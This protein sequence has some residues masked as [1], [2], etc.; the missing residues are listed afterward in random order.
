MAVNTEFLGRTYPT[1]GPY[2]VTAEGVAAFADAV[3]AN[4]PIHRDVA[5]ARA[6]GYAG[7]VAPPTFIVS[8][9]QQCNRAYIADPDAGIDFSRLVH[10]E[11]SF[12]HHR[13]L[14]AGDAVS[15]AT[16]VESIRQA[17]GHSMITMRTDL[18]LESGEP[19][20][21]ARST[22]VIRGGE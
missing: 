21:T 2:L 10:G 19:V 9:E 8:L 20:C 5:R 22:V 3:G 13:P 4:D 18:T 16:T 6:A 15:G 7:V 11:Q 17:G 12:V 1:S 14:V